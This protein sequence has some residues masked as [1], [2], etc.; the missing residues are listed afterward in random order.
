[1]QDGVLV[2]HFTERTEIQYQV[3]RSYVYE[4]LQYFL[5]STQ[6]DQMLFVRKPTREESFR[7][8]KHSSILTLPNAHFYIVLNPKIKNIKESDRLA[9]SLGAIL[10]E[11]GVIAS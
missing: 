8:F 1:M 10:K 2:L 5:I 7:H 9:K 3:I 4:K 6:E 11:K